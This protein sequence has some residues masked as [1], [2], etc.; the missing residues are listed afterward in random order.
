MLILEQLPFFELSYK[1]ANFFRVLNYTWNPNLKQIKMDRSLKNKRRVERICRAHLIFIVT[2]AIQ[3]GFPPHTL[4]HE[5]RLMGLASLFCNVGAGMY[6]Q[7]GT[8]KSTEVV[9][10]IN[11]I[12]KFAMDYSLPEQSITERKTV[13]MIDKVNILVAKLTW[14]TCIS[15]G[16]LI[17]IGFHL[18]NPCKPSLAGY[19]ILPECL[20]R[21]PSNSFLWAVINKILKAFIFTLNWWLISVATT[22]N[23]FIFGGVQIVGVLTLRDFLRRFAFF[24]SKLSKMLRLVIILH[25]ISDLEK[26]WMESHLMRR[27]DLFRATDPFK[28]WPR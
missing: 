11:G 23:A 19:L 8:A 21:P 17:G 16:A 6:L 7:A 12:L 1:T 13:K 5:D 25:L 2:L 15:L 10:L 14:L 4:S 20:A 22:I 26:D 28:S 18:S 27:T 24:Y 3:A 9:G